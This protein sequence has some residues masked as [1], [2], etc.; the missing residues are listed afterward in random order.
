MNFNLSF[1][2]TR[3]ILSRSKRN[4]AASRRGYV[5][6]AGFLGTHDSRYCRPR[7]MTRL[8]ALVVG[9][10]TEQADTKSASPAPQVPHQRKG[11]IDH[12]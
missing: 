4:T 3:S 11:S 6:A 2:R 7:S 5:E 1:L 8:E 9:P 12:G 10:G